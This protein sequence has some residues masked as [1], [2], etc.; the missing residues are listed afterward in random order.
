M[1]QKSIKFIFPVYL[2]TVIYLL[3]MPTSNSGIDLNF[4]ILGI[5]SDH[6]IHAIMMSPFMFFCFLLKK[7][8]HFIIYL[9]IGIFFCSFCESLHYF[10]PYRDFSIQDF[11]ANLSG[12]SF[13]SIIF[14]I[15]KTLSI[16]SLQ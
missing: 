14:L 3:V 13:G 4:S 16:K 5:R 12:L 15:L 10:I 1:F 8:I 6:W 7:D 9:F 11:Y 2:L